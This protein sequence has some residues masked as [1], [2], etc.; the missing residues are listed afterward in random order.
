MA[1]DKPLLAVLI[2]GDNVPAKHATAIFEELASFGEAAV[3]RIYGDSTSSHL[4]GWRKLFSKYAI[5]PVDT[6]AYT[7][8]KNSSDMA[9]AIDAM[10]LF[11]TGRFNGF[12]IVSSDSD[13]TR[14]ASKLRED[15]SDVYGIGD[16]NTNEAFRNA[17]NRF[18]YL[19]TLGDDGDCVSQAS[20]SAIQNS[21]T[22]NGTAGTANM[23]PQ[24][25]AVPLVLKAMKSIDPELTWYQLG[26]VGNVIVRAN[27]DFD[28]RN[29][30]HKTLSELVTKTG[31][32]EIRKQ[33]GCDAE[34]R[35]RR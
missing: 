16:Q 7:A 3:R 10:E 14:L 19:E 22:S 21:P 29:Y 9:L 34:I 13:F 18:L 32:F 23:M 4:D 2:D 15:G 30:G 17:C 25:K 12:V 6:P 33:D 1:N 28:P 24:T 35:R 27:P 8:R 26:H 31:A 20:A 11:H 5:Q